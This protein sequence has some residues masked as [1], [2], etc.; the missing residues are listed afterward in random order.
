VGAWL[1]LVGASDAIA[2]AGDDEAAAP[3]ATGEPRPQAVTTV[4]S[5]PTPTSQRS[6]RVTART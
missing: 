6:P 3:P 2:A 4:T 1:V 5:T